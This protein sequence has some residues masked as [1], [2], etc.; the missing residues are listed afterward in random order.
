MLVIVETIIPSQLAYIFAYTQG[1]PDWGGS[2]HLNSC[3]LL[4]KQSSPADGKSKLKNYYF[5]H[6]SKI[7][8]L[9]DYFS[10]FSEMI[11]L[12][13]FQP[14]DFAAFIS[15]LENEE[16]LFQIAGKYFTFPLTHDQ[17]QNYLAD[18]KSI[19]FNVRDTVQNK[20]VGH[21]EIIYWGIAV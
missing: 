3:E 10:K 12:T 7:E 21:P 5:Y 11:K 2:R 13:P 19:S 4:P 1:L 18:E 14:S 20:I 8:I 9:N 15:W 6:V 16:L 17:L